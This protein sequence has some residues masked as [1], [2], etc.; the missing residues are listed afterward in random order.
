MGRRSK[1][2]RSGEHLFNVN[3]YALY[4]ES[5]AQPPPPPREQLGKREREEPQVRVEAPVDAGDIAERGYLERKFGIK[6]KGPQRK[7]PKTASIAVALPLDASTDDIVK[8]REAARAR[9]D[10][11][12]A[13][14]LRDALAERGVK[15]Q[16][17]Y[18]LS[19]KKAAKH[20][21][22]AIKK[23]KKKTAKKKV[24]HQKKKEER[25]QMARVKTLALGVEIED[26]AV[27]SGVPV[28][29][30][31]RVRVNYVG[32]LETPTGKVFDRSQASHPFSF[33]LGKGDV[34]KGWDI[35][36]QG[37]KGGGRRRITVP[38]K[39]GYGG[40]KMPGIPPH[41]TLVF[42]VTVVA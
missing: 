6:L 3:D 30:R 19:K 35:G 22:E 10:W 2:Q 20:E 37:M 9:N 13:D 25:R 28:V 42:D 23:Q 31:K 21:R 1:S 16:D 5:R 41:S 36:I 24:D 26:L 11:A 32:R 33:K 4:E 14:A 39:A 15:C 40:K 27:G 18:A 8:L 17:A 7:R 12:T 38:P 29:D 34:I